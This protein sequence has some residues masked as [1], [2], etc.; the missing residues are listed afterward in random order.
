MGVDPVS[1]IVLA[2]AAI[3]AQNKMERDR[4]VTQ[5]EATT[6]RIGEEK[7]MTERIAQQESDV[8]AA[9]ASEK[10]RN[11]AMSARARQKSAAAAA[12]SSR[13]GLA[14][15]TLLGGMNQPQGQASAKT[16]LGV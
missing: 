4:K 14:G 16:L 11:A 9:D 6:A 12:A 8:A 3:A 7:K 2:G 5:D 13:Y 15:G 1:W 10:A